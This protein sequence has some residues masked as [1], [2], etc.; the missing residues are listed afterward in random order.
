MKSNKVN[1]FV[2]NIEKYKK[3]LEKSSQSVKYLDFRVGRI[4]YPYFVTKNSVYILDTVL[5]QILTSSLEEV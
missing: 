3:V 5:H 1:C 4:R 2:V